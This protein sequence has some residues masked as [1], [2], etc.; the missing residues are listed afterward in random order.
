[1]VLQVSAWAQNAGT[2]LYTTTGGTPQWQIRP[3]LS[4]SEHFSDN[5]AL[6]PAGLARNEWT[7]KIR[8]SIW[9]LGNG[10][11]FRLNAFYAPELLN[12]IVE[13]NTS[14]SHFLDAGAQAELLTG[15]FFVDFKAGASQQAKSLLA[16]Q[17]DS[18]INTTTNRTSIRTYSISPYL[19]HEFGAD[20]IGVFRLTHDA[21]R[22]S[23]AGSVTDNASA[24]SSNS[25]SNRMNMTLGSGPA[26]KLMTWN[27]DLSKSHVE[28]E[29]TGQKVD[30][31]RVSAA[32]GRL[33]M[34]D[35]RLNVEVG[36]EDSGYPNSLGQ[37]LKG[38]FW[39]VGPEW[40]PSP[41]TR[42]SATYG[43]RYFGPFR[44]FQID[45]RSRHSVWALGYSEGV[46]TSR[47]NQTVR[48]PT[49]LALLKDA[50]LR[51]D[52]QFQDPIVRQIEVQNRVAATPGGN[53][54]EPL[55]F[56]TDAL[57][58]DK[59]LQ[60]TLG[61]QSNENSILA[62]LFMSNRNALSSGPGTGEEF[63]AAQ[64]VKQSGASLAW[65]LRLTGTFTSSLKLSANRNSFD[66]LNRTDRLTVFEWGL[67]EQFTP[68]VTGSFNIGR[69]NANSNQSNFN[70]RENSITVTLG[71]RY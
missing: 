7:T 54:T 44:S 15:T 4:V 9:V 37:K 65:N 2:N 55:N 62:G 42:M 18:N 38:T 36:Y 39:S 61:I 27:L 24:I 8:P 53:L 45:H 68:K 69:R 52:P 35:V 23:D 21:M 22:V 17:A 32:I 31:E 11:R 40:T 50:E 66:R 59:R 34:P 13:N 33:I 30:A 28:Y 26:Y 63:A 16:P 58:L 46:A 3:S 1:M 6:A 71:V 25:S 12:R 29:Q 47:Y 41:R 51:N 70:Y 19:R 57:F 43:H 20:A 14:F 67:A 48:V 5:I 60:A 49:T 64:S 56:L 10:T